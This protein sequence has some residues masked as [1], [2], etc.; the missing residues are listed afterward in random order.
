MA[1]GY[2]VATT[3][4]R[5][6]IGFP[7]LQAT[8]SLFTY[9]YLKIRTNVVSKHRDQITLWRNVTCQKNGILRHKAAETLKFAVVSLF[10]M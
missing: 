3:L 4:R 2:F 10:K 7:G 8:W 6:V 1:V 5:W 9:T